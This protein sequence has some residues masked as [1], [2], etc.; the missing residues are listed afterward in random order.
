M[1]DSE[2]EYEINNLM[3]FKKALTYETTS[4]IKP[5]ITNGCIIKSCLYSLLRA[6]LNE[7]TQ[8]VYTRHVQDQAWSQSPESGP[9][10]E[11]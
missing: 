4:Y 2:P 8:N 10:N 1:C 9:R 5:I 11:T 6:T 3:L 7:F